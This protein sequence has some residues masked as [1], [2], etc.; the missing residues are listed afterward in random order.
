MATVKEVLSEVVAKRLMG[1]LLTLVE[2]TYSDKVQREA[3]KSFVRQSCTKALK[4]LTE[5]LDKQQVD[6]KPVSTL[7]ATVDVKLI[8]GGALNGRNQ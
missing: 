2:A 5:Q 6:Q 4:D 7:T 1:E 3:V 8:K